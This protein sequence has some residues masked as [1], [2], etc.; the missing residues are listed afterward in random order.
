MRGSRTQTVGAFVA[1]MFGYFVDDAPQKY[2][3]AYASSLRGR[4]KGASFGLGASGALNMRRLATFTILALALCC[5]AA[6]APNP[7]PTQM[8][9]LILAGDIDGF[10]ARARSDLAPGEATTASAVSR[11]RASGLA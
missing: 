3:L 2:R 8:T 6:A 9:D 5:A 11:A 1:F 7:A 4:K 10:I